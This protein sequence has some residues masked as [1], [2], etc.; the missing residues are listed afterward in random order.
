MIIDCALYRQGRRTEG[1]LSIEAAAR[2]RLEED[3]FVWIG[4]F[5]PS[6]G[7]L[8]QVTLHFG[9]HELAV[10]DAL[11]AHQR[12]KL[13]RYEDMLLVVLK[14]A[15][16]VDSEEVV[17]LGEIL[18]FVGDDFL[19]SVRHGM[20]SSLE[21]LR[22]ELQSDPEFLRL[23]PSAVLH[24]IV[25]R[26]VDEYGPV[27]RGLEHDIE[28]VE[29]QV[30]SLDRDNPTERIYYLTREVL[31]FHRATAPLVAPLASLAERDERHIHQEVRRYFRDA[32][33][34]LVRIHEQ[35]MAFRDLLTS[36]LEANLAQMGVRQNED[37]RKISAWVAIAVVPT[38][39][40]GIYGM[41]FQHMPELTARWGYPTV[42]GVMLA[43]CAGLFAFF[44]ARKWL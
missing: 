20:A 32:H 23:G 8:E 43:A 35:V 26:V 19:I 2:A 33:D 4:L 31:D 39:I 41:N 18:L 9:L 21:G 25:D 1:R 38:M 28:E 5:E 7:E 11:K 44:R 12:P 29:D 6:E 17:E 40:A 3:A 14:T 22:R 42:M 27:V 24:G 15:R 13:E 10:E 34:H 30:F 36:I 37:M 16:Y